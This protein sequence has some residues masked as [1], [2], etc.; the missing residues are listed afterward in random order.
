VESELPEPVLPTQCGLLD[1]GS[2]RTILK[3]AGEN[4]KFVRY[5]AT[6][7]GNA[8]KVGASGRQS[9]RERIAADAGAGILD[10]R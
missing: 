1:A 3:E 7:F 9:T 8:R 5:V 4:A 6:S 2:G 10:G